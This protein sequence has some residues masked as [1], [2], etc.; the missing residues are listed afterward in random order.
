MDDFVYVDSDIVINE[1]MASNDVT[2]SDEFGEFD[3]WIEIYNKG[4]V[5]VNLGGLHLS[6]DPLILGKYTFPDITLS[7]NEYFIVWA[8]DDEEDQGDDYHATFKL[9]SS[10]EELYLS[11]ED[12]NILD[13]VFFGEQ[14]TDIG[15][16]RVPNGV[17][18]FVIQFPTFSFN[19]DNASGTIELSDLSSQIIKTIDVLGRE[20][21]IRSGFIVDLYSNGHCQKYFI[22]K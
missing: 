14:E 13:A 21:D 7:P 17:G 15:Y 18:D 6:D 5:S 10:G 1:L 12:F 9:S 8:D 16:A 22:H 3:D 11:D 2:V 4:S 20:V 19:N